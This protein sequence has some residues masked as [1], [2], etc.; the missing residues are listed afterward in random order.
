MLCQTEPLIRGID[1][2]DERSSSSSLHAVLDTLFPVTNVP[3]W[4]VGMRVLVLG[5]TGSIGGPIV[6]ELIR[7][8]H[9]VV[10]LARSEVSAKK[11][12]E[13]GA[14]PIS[15]DISRPEPWLSAL[16]C[17][18][19]VIHAAA[20]FANDEEVADRCL[21]QHLLPF[22]SAMPR[23]TRFVYTGGC[24]LFGATNGT[25]TTEDSPF[26][27]LAFLAWSVSHIRWVLDAPGIEP[28]VIH[29]AMVYEPCG[30]V[31]GRFYNDATQRNA[32]RVVAEAVRWPLVH[33]ED[34]ATL[35]RLALE[36]GVPGE[37]Y[38]GAAIE[39]TPVGH[40]ARAFAR[41]FGTRCP[42]PV[43]MSEDDI[44]A[45]LGD[46]AQGHARDQRLSGDKARRCL[47][48]EPAHLDPESEIA[49]VP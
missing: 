9:D 26:D 15:G 47:G 8:G 29:P 21:L 33:S 6:R 41:R 43:L 36:R 32:V 34:L 5:G 20:T 16:P 31:F 12:A 28:L 3:A 11:V 19:G 14:R 48:W 1:G 46:W 22:L 2:L 42:D 40:I 37:S 49:S 39:G 7:Y 25:V 13:S 17:V 30:G 44:A 27:P 38:L 23:K 10:A 18:D 45:E 35:Y 4:E 24:W